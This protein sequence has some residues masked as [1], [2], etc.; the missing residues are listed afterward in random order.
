MRRA[1]SIMQDC[2]HTRSTTGRRAVWLRPLLATCALLVAGCAPHYV[3]YR[4][5]VNEP[6]PREA[7]ARYRIGPSDEL[8][9][10]SQ[11]VRELDS[12]RVTVQAD[13][14]IT[15]P[16]LDTQRAAGLTRDELASSLAEA[17]ERYYESPKIRVTVA[18]HAS[19]RIFVIGAVADPGAQPFDGRNTALRALAKAR[20][21]KRADPTRIIVLAPTGDGRFE[22]RAKLNL[23]AIA[24]GADEQGAEEEADVWLGP[25]EIVRVP[26]HAWR[27]PER[28]DT[29]AA[30][31]RR[32]QR[33]MRD[34]RAANKD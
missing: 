26:S 29:R 14:T 28:R 7:A 22:Q 25:G 21:T 10:H 17:A 31:I 8:R 9:L 3:D 15:L 23:R 34:M 11:T 24:Q 2:G 20:P 5:F 13:G 27:G 6:T 33:D 16:L 19:Q 18:R 32:D 12:E 30:A 4:P 1:R